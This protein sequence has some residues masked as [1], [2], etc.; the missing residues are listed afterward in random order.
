[1]SP[2]RS[3]LEEYPRDQKQPAEFVAQ[4]YTIPSLSADLGN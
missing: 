2:G 1:M 3:V 4:Y